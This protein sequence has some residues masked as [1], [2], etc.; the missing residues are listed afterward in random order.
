MT[1]VF[2]HA[3]YTKKST[4][5]SRHSR[6]LLVFLKTSCWSLWGAV[7]MKLQR[8]RFRVW[9][10]RRHGH[11][12]HQTDREHHRQKEQSTTPCHPSLR[13]QQ[14]QSPPQNLRRQHQHQPLPHHH[15]PSLKICFENLPAK[16]STVCTSKA[17]QNF[18]TCGLSLTMT[19][20]R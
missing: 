19:S 13:P 5:A 14:K 10:V 15:H 7:K 1:T 8:L 6:I 9:L 20:S 4:N 12:R 16:T 11:H 2:L 3:K 17:T 18:K